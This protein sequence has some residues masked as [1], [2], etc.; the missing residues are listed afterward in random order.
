MERIAVIILA[1]GKGKRMRSSLVKVLHPLLGRPMLSYPLEV[2]LGQLRPEKTLVVIGYQGDEVRVAFPD[3]R[4]TFVEQQEQLGTGHA[5]S[6]TKP[7]LGDFNGTILIL[8]GDIPLVRPQTLRGMLNHHWGKEAVLTLLT[9]HMEDPTGYGR[10]VRGVLG[11]V[12]KVV[13]EKDATDHELEI[14]EVNSGIYCVQAPFLFRALEELSSDN[15]QQ[16]YYLTDIIEIAHH[17][18]KRICTFS[19]PDPWEIMGVNTRAE[20]AKAEE[21]LGERVRRHW[22]SEGVTIKNPQSVYIEPDVRIG[23]DTLI[24][25][26]CYLRGKTSIG[27]LLYTSPSP[28]D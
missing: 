14:K 15:A 19:V 5:V 11:G 26:N 24:Y 10:V 16:E 21:V 18:K 28:R 9:S 20:L 1:A 2:T 3:P 6:V 22:M 7:L 25:P 23:K 4:I 27:C 8:C 13:E 17:K 12:R